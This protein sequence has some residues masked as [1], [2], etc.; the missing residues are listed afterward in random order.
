MLQVVFVFFLRTEIET[1]LRE[2]RCGPHTLRFPPV[3]QG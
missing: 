2:L 3:L 1:H